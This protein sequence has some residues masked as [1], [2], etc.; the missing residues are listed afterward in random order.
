[1]SFLNNPDIAKLLLRLGVGLLML[2]HGVAKLIKGV[3]GIK[4]MLSYAGLPEFMAYGVYVG[5]IIAPILL[6]IGLKTRSAATLIIFTMIVAIYVAHPNDIFVLNRVR[7]PVIELPLF[8]IFVSLAIIFL[9][10]GKY[11]V[12]K[13]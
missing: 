8:Y 2:F 10:A 5:E 9:G 6:V 3:D 4:G 11:S 12:D 7:A 13:S 1:M